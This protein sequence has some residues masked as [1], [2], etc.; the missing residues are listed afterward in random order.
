MPFTAE[1]IQTKTYN[2]CI[3]CE[4][5]GVS[6][7]GPNMA[8]MT[9]ERFCEW[10]KLRK[11]QLGWS[12]AKLAEVSGCSKGTIDRLVS[13]LATGINAET[14]SR[15]AC[16]LIYQKPYEVSWGKY[17]CTLALQSDS[18]ANL[19]EMDGLRSQVALMEKQL[20]QQS[21]NDRTK[22]EH[23]KEENEFYKSQMITKDKQLEDRAWFIKR[24]DRMIVILAILLGI[25][26]F[27][28][29]A[30]LIVDRLNPNVGFFWREA[31]AAFIP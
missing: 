5:L 29:F 10:C 15:I 28:I 23:L 21:E 25:S 6:C 18:S 31:L 24:K 13:G 16:A 26:V 4:N 8:A 11:E 30:G 27:L 12:N 20:H 2:Q 19:A 1:T 22:I 14:K 3:I 7:D 9:M 17:P